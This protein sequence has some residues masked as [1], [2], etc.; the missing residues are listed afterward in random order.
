MPAPGHAPDGHVAGPLDPAMPRQASPGPINPDL[1][2]ALMSR[3]WSAGIEVAAIGA[4]VGDGPLSDR[5]TAIVGQLDSVIRDIR[6]GASAPPA[7]TG[8]FGAS[9][10]PVPDVAV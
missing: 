4:L 5:A 3:I 9:G 10:L 6:A 1:A 7:L 2:L 8:R